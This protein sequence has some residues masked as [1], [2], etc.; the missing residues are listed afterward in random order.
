MTVV[1]AREVVISMQQYREKQIFWLLEF[2]T[3]KQTSQGLELL[4]RGTTPP[5][6]NHIICM[7][8]CI[9]VCMYVY[10][11]CMY[12]NMYVFMYVCMYV[13]MY[14]CTYVPREGSFGHMQ[15]LQKTSEMNLIMLN[16]NMYGVYGSEVTWGHS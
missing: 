9:H 6:I 15:K 10:I 3:D 2:V 11:V 8:V 5:E 16:N 14:A 4:P 13:Y 7:Y 1:G 12:V